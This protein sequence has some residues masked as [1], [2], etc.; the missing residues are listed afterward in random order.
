M[1]LKGARNCGV[2]ILEIFLGI[3]NS[4]VSSSS[5]NDF[6]YGEQENFHIEQH[7]V[8]GNVVDVQLSVL[9]HG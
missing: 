6:E 1:R 8:I 3:R 9:V 4:L 5:F 2:N 7:G